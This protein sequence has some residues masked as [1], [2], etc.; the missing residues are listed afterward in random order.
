MGRR[1]RGLESTR[2]TKL[3]FSSIVNVNWNRCKYPNSRQSFEN[4]NLAVSYSG[5]ITTNEHIT[6][7]ITPATVSFR[8]I[9]CFRSNTII[10]VF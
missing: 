9:A 1:R 10:Y 6:N 7:A 5:K 3:S 2:T 8:F 4:R